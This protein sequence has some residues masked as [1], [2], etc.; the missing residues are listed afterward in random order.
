MPRLLDFS[1][2]QKAFSDATNLDDLRKAADGFKNAIATISKQAATTAEGAIAQATLRAALPP[3]A[4]ADASVTQLLQQLDGGYATVKKARDN[5]RDGANGLTGLSRL[6]KDLSTL[7]IKITGT[8]L[9]T[10]LDVDKLDSTQDDNLRAIC[11]GTPNLPEGL[12]QEQAVIHCIAATSPGFARMKALIDLF[13]AWSATPPALIRL[14]TDLATRAKK[15]M[16]L[17]PQVN[18]VDVTSLRQALSELIQD[19]IPSKRHL[20]YNWVLPFKSGVIGIGDGSLAS[21]GLPDR[22]TLTANTEID[23][24]QINQTPKFQISGTL[25]GFSVNIWKVADYAV[26]LEFHPFSFTAGS[27]SS[28]HFSADLSGVKIGGTLV[29]LTALAAYFQAQSGD[30]SG[31]VGDGQLPERS[32]HH[33]QR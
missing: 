18:F 11:S 30:P 8:P 21:F 3:I 16:T 22:L 26:V 7:G 1:I 29:F 20:E 17:P 19:A 23:L 5:L 24:L 12:D 9:A 13:D 14:V 6:Q 25:G 31:G 4:A 2:Q 27:G 33:S 28:P 15:V 10:I 32:L